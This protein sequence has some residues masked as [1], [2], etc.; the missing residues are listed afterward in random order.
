[1][2]CAFTGRRTRKR[3]ARRVRNSAVARYIDVGTCDFQRRVSE[4]WRGMSAKTVATVA[5]MV[6]I[7]FAGTSRS[8]AQSASCT[9][10]PTAPANAA[11]SVTSAGNARTPALV[12]VQWV[13]A[14]PGPNAAPSYVVEVGDAPGITNISQFDTGETALSTVQPAAT[15]TY[16]VRVR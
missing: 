15:G 3:Q 7:S 4:G 1:M 14:A 16:Y 6:L 10:P 2:P 13:G 8:F 12:T 11:A 9:A 5:F